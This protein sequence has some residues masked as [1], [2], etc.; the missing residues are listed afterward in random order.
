[1]LSVTET[2]IAL[3]KGMFPS[4]ARNGERLYLHRVIAFSIVDDWAIALAVGIDTN[5]LLSLF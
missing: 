5:S 1:M 2:M 3:V 4:C